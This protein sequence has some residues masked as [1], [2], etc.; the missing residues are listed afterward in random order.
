[1]TSTVLSREQE[2]SAATLNATAVATE[3]GVGEVFTPATEPPC[4]IAD[5]TV[6]RCPRCQ[7]PS[8]VRNLKYYHVCSRSWDPQVRAREEADKTNRLCLAN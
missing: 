5:R 3:M 6:M 2:M 4:R 7:R 8:Q 1:M